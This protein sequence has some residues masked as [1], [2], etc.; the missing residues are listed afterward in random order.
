MDAERFVARDTKTAL[1]RVKAKLGPDALILS[2]QRSDSGIEITAISGSVITDDKAKGVTSPST[3]S[4]N[5][6]TLGYLDRELKALRDV[7]Y[8]ALGER[9]WQ[10]ASGREP[11]LSAVEQR[12]HTLGLSKL[13]IDEA[14]VNVDFAKGLNSSWSAVLANLT[15][16]IDLA[17]DAAASLNATPTAVIGGTSGCRSLTCQHLIE[18]SIRDNVKPSQFLVISHT[19]DPSGALIDFCKRKGIKR[20]QVT[21]MSEVRRCLKRAGGRRKVVIE[22]EDLK[23]GLGVNDP[24]LELFAD[25]ELTV[26]AVLVVSAIHQSEFLRSIDQHTKH[27]PVIG[28]VI[29]RT[30]E[31]ISLG[32]ILDFFILGEL[33]LIGVIRQRDTVVQR[34][35]ASG[36]VN[37]AK[38]LARER[39]EERKLKSSISAYSR[40]ALVL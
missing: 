31:A 13:A 6:I 15:S 5:E 28:A 21:S 35:T 36:L 39:V 18:K 10:E 14:K 29:S 17:S 37:L 8:N 22:T 20:I 11:V 19:Q 33:S 2:T 7:L 38:R 40:T 26:E 16:S 34:I 9:N 30:C 24:V 4:V 3:E 1:E 32:A 27:L 23:P 25:R 12:L